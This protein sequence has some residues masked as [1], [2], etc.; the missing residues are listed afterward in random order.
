MALKGIIWDFDGVILDSFEDQF[1]WF[2]KVCRIFSKPF[3]YTNTEDFRR[4]FREPVCPAMYDLLGFDWNNERDIIWEYYHEHKRHAKI[5]L[6][7]GIEKAITELDASGY[8]QCI[9]SSN[10]H[11]G[12]EKR[13]DE[14]ELRKYF[15]IIVAKEDLPIENNEPRYKPH[16]DCLLICFERLGLK[17]WECVYI[18]DQVSDI[19][20]ARNVKSIAG[21]NLPVIAVSY[22][23]GTWQSLKAASPDYPK[24]SPIET[25]EELL[26][27]IRRL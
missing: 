2:R 25:P 6:V 15:P 23:Y 24:E 10:A 12:I 5:R 4:D 3:V 20:A 22:G 9:A 13:L 7:R 18:G 11:E 14:N 21:A 27:I 1:E 26:E 19:K 8:K 16:P 17:P